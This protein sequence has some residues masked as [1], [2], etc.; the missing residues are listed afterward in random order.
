[1]RE[2]VEGSGA[3]TSEDVE[4]SGEDV[5]GSR[6]RCGNPSRKRHIPSKLL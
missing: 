5:E 6:S 1:M 3:G 4:G 2:D